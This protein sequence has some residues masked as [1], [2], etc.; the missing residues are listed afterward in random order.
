V[1]RGGSEARVL[2]HPPVA[3]RGVCAGLVWLC[4]PPD[5]DE[6]DGFDEVRVSIA[7]P[8]VATLP[9]LTVCARVWCVS[10][11]GC[12][13]QTILPLDFERTGQIVDDVSA[14]GTHTWGVPLTAAATHAYS[15]SPHADT[16]IGRVCLSTYMPSAYTS[17]SWP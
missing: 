13:R 10:G 14:V 4:P 15:A 5:K 8:R 7:R 17:S 9:S 2:L 11:C 3:S 1:G 16:V 12:A 6:A